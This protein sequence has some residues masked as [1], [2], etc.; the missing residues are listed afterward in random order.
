MASILLEITGEMERLL[1]LG[2]SHKIPEHVPNS[3]KKE[4]ESDKKT[5]K[6]LAI[7]LIIHIPLLNRELIF[8]A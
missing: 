2:N 4:E 6:T 5:L 1:Y 8:R 7:L 3:L